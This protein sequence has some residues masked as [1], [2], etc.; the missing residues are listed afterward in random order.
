MHVVYSKCQR[1]N[2]VRKKMGQSMAVVV[3]K[4]KFPAENQVYSH[5]YRMQSCKTS[6]IECK[7]WFFFLAQILNVNKLIKYLV[8]IITGTCWIPQCT[9][10]IETDKWP[11]S[12]SW[13]NDLCF[14]SI[15]I[16]FVCANSRIKHIWCFQN[17]HP[18]MC[19]CQIWSRP[20][21]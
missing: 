2:V 21:N 9:A 12:L 19:G 13:S 7:T 5:K 17:S 8:S 16:R 15:R 14:N 18:L 6:T 3:P 10:R 1:V 11:S 4:V 20:L